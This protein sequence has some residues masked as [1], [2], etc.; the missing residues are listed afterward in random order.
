MYA[1]S[2]RNNK[3]S[4]L[5]VNFNKKMMEYVLDDLPDAVCVVDANSCKVRTSNRRFRH[6]I[7]SIATDLSFLDNFVGKEDM[8]RF[9]TALKSVKQKIGCD[10][11]T[12]GS[13]PIIRDCE[14]LTSASRYCWARARG[15][16][17]IG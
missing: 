2:S 9:E 16:R 15:T 17:L 1:D 4:V 5:H 12:W 11:D 7:S 6:T 10:P 3:F 13:L 8:A 14:T